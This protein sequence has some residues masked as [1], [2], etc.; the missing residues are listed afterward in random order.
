MK[1][2]SLFIFLFIVN[3]GF[4]QNW[5]NS[6]DL[7]NNDISNEVYRKS[8]IGV[9]FSP[10]SDYAAASAGRTSILGQGGIVGHYS[11]GVVGDLFES[12]WCGLGLGN[13]GGAGGVFP[14]GLAA[15]DKGHLAFYNIIDKT[16]YRKDVVAGYGFASEE[17]N[18]NRFRIVH[19]NKATLLTGKDILIA[20]SRGAVGINGEPFAALSV[21]TRASA[22][23]GVL[24][25]ETENDGFI[26]KSI[27]IQGEQFV[28]ATSSSLISTASAMGNQANQ[29]L[30][31]SAIPVEG[32][33]AQIPAFDQTPTRSASI[34][35]DFQAVIDRG[36]VSQ[37]VGPAIPAPSQYGE[38][39]WQ[40]LSYIGKVNTDCETRNSNKNFYISFRNGKSG[41]TAPGVIDPDFGNAFSKLN[42]LPVATFTPRGRV[43]IGTIEPTCQNGTTPVLL[44]VA[45]GVTANALFIGSDKRFKKDIKTIENAL[46]KI[47]ALRGTT[48][49]YDRDNFPNRNFKTG[50][51]YGF[52]AQE[53]EKV[54][55]EMATKSDD[56]YYA[57]EYVA[58]I[59]VLTEAIKEQ[60]QIITDQATRLN[61]LETINEQLQSSHEQLKSEVDALRNTKAVNAGY[62]IFQNVP[63]PTSGKTSIAYEISQSFTSASINVYDLNGRYV[64]GFDLK[65]SK[66]AISLSLDNL[67]PGMYIYDLL[68][69]GEQK[70][71]K[72][73]TL[74]NRS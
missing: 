64:Q 28:D 42:K 51:S 43:G 63:N 11:F 33:R 12:K 3:F 60:D 21:D 57:V 56:G 49:T 58:L 9:G 47:K 20:N 18:V 1:K 71:V 48:Y 52:I 25:P 35:V 73:M 39:T 26:S 50:M 59:P 15:T 36:T 53:V 5:N 19:Y 4:A 67:L 44:T 69:D 37:P 54:I 40:D 55:P 31:L 65:D 13:P 46:D 6:G 16:G 14:Y 68:I 61:Q 8:P 32:M 17:R 41:T 38:I 72:K 23:G 27:A 62:K 24:K 45:G 30:A 7:G 22:N 10:W 29:S 2:L 34:G 74:I 66:G 70:A